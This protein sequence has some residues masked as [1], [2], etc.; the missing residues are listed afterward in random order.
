VPLTLSLLS[1]VSTRLLRTLFS[2]HCSSDR[3][4]FCREKS[5]PYYRFRSFSRMSPCRA[6]DTLPVKRFPCFPRDGL[7][8]VV[9]GSENVFSRRFFLFDLIGDDHILF[10][11]DCFFHL[12]KRLFLQVAQPV[13]ESSTVLGVHYSFEPFFCLLFL[14]F[15]CWSLKA[16]RTQG[17]R[18]SNLPFFPEELASPSSPR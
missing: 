3:I 6:C 12:E 5:T 13:K 15:L 14:F 11:F 9:P 4:S 16:L 2:G 7:A 10:H 17:T 8:S 18:S 1:Q